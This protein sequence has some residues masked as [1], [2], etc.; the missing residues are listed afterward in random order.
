MKVREATES[1]RLTIF[2]VRSYIKKARQGYANAGRP[3]TNVLR[4]GQRLVEDGHLA[5]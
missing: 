4:L 5:D 1:L 3:S 2:T